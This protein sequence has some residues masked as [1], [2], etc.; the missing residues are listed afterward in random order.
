[1]HLH[2]LG[3][4]RH[5]LEYLIVYRIVLVQKGWMD[6]QVFN[7]GMN[8]SRFITSDCVGKSQIKFLDD[9]TCYSVTEELEQTL[10]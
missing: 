9:A 2:N 1:M 8:E 3:I 5:I 4:V 6:R 10:S 7:E